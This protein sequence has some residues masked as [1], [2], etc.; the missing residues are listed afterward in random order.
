MNYQFC[1]LTKSEHKIEMD[2]TNALTHFR[3]VL[4]SAPPVRTFIFTSD[5]YTF[6]NINVHKRCVIVPPRGS[7]ASLFSLVQ[8]I[9]ATLSEQPKRARNARSLSRG[10]LSLK[11]SA[12]MIMFALRW[13]SSLPGCVSRCRFDGLLVAMVIKEWIGQTQSKTSIVDTIW[14]R[15]NSARRLGTISTYSFSCFNFDL[16]E[17]S[18]KQKPIQLM[19]RKAHGEPQVARRTTSR[20]PNHKL[21]T[22]PQVYTNSVPVPTWSCFETEVARQNRSRT[23]KQKSHAEPQTCIVYPLNGKKEMLIFI[24]ENKQYFWQAWSIPVPRS[25]KSLK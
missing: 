6:K 22:E 23:P 5:G 12:C 2:P 1:Q 10:A 16:D 9:W 19:N 14:F 21:H 24:D 4:L 18:W 13:K 11:G 25:Q 8:R 7:K 17:K 20:T 3:I 15:S